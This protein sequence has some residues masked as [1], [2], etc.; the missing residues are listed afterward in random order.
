MGWR[1]GPGHSAETGCCALVRHLDWFN[2][3]R[4]EAKP[5]T[6]VRRMS[7]YGHLNRTKHQVVYC[8]GNWA[9]ERRA[10]YLC[11]ADGLFDIDGRRPKR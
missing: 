2:V 11:G 6:G 7:G 9:V 3:T 4:M 1:Q 10:A 5:G 8:V